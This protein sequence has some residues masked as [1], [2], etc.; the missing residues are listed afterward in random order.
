M[1][2]GRAVQSWC[3]IAAAIPANQLLSDAAIFPQNNLKIIQTLSRTDDKIQPTGWAAECRT[4]VRFFRETKNAQINTKMHFAT[5][6]RK[7]CI[8]EIF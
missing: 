4:V 3:R 6:Y 8:C 1:S 2:P 7:S 5:K